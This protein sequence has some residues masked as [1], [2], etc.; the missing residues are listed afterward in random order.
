[1]TTTKSDMF[2]FGTN[3]LSEDQRENKHIDGLYVKVPDTNCFIEKANKCSVFIGTKPYK[4]EVN[5]S[6]TYRSFGPDYWIFHSIK[7]Y[8]YDDQEYV[9][10][11]IPN[12]CVS[13]YIAIR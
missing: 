4:G 10:L 1:M 3:F 9:I 5:L 8:D 13:S 7:I 11:K 6:K 2:H 12:P